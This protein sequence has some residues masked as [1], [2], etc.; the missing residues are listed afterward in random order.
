[1]Q[2]IIIY[3]E[4]LSPRVI[5]DAVTGQ[6]LKM[7]GSKRDLVSS[8]VEEKGLYAALIQR[9]SLTSSIACFFAL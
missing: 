1:M 2:K 4:S 9:M 3:T 7:V 6:E 8:L 5:A